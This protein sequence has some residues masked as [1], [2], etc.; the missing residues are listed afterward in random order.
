MLSKT[1]DQTMAKAMK[2][3]NMTRKTTF[4]RGYIQNVDTAKDMIEKLSPYVKSEKSSEDE[5]LK[6]I[7]EDPNIISPVFDFDKCERTGLPFFKSLSQKLNI[8]PVAE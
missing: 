5:I 7:V 1:L 3:E 2:L 6:Y 8:M 4:G